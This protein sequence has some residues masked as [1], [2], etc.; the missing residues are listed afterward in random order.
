MADDYLEENSGDSKDL[1]STRTDGDEPSEEGGFSRRGRR[2]KLSVER[3][4]KRKELAII[5]EEIKDIRTLFR[6]YDKIQ[7]FS[8][9]SFFISLSILIA[10]VAF[11]SRYFRLDDSGWKGPV[12]F[13]VLLI[14]VYFL[15]KIIKS[16]IFFID[17]K[18]EER[19][20]KLDLVGLNLRYEELR[21]LRYELLSQL[22]PLTAFF[23]HP[24]PLKFILTRPF[25]FVFVKN[26]S[27]SDRKSR[28][29]KEYKKFQKLKKKSDILYS[30]LLRH[31][32]T[33]F[34]SSKGSVLI[35][36]FM[37]GIIA[38]SLVNL[39]GLKDSVY[40]NLIFIVSIL[41][42]YL[43]I[44]FFI[45]PPHLH[46]SEE[47][48]SALSKEFYKV[49]A[50]SYQISRELRLPFYFL[51]APLIKRI[52]KLSYFSLQLIFFIT[53]AIIFLSYLFTNLS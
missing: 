22:N 2:G 38:Y 14:F 9:L 43:V 52:L 42:N 23:Y 45:L 13:I 6:R 16:K 26:F 37:G 18:E 36:F 34:A 8:E 25:Y 5:E 35:A 17:P 12:W 4:S 28:A 49:S 47:D 51:E 50:E 24:S 10:A 41:L 11:S 29:A 1:S 20:E 3:D 46:L 48:Y 44:K 53:I 33:Y 27:S 15:H 40:S 32:L 21:T 31:N 19:L 30:I 39:L 7:T